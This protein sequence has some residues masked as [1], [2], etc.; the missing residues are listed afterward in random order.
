MPINP[1]EALETGKFNQDIDL[2]FGT[3]SDEG[4]LFVESLFPQDLS[5]QIKNPTIT[6]QKAKTY[7]RLMYLIFKEKYG[8][9]VADFLPQWTYR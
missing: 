6:V 4:A 1:V 8:D 7:I 5:P 3:V 2:M 9:A